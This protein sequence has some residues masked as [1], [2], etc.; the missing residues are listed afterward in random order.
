[1]KPLRSANS[2]FKREVLLTCI[3]SLRVLKKLINKLN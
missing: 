1:M 2:G 3:L